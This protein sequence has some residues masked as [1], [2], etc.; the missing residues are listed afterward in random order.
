[1]CGGFTPFVSGMRLTTLR[2]MS[3]SIRTSSATM[4]CW[5]IISCAIAGCTNRPA[6]SQSLGHVDTQTC[7][8]STV[9]LV[10]SARAD[11]SGVAEHQNTRQRTDGIRSIGTI[12]DNRD[13]GGASIEVA[14]VSVTKD[15]VA[16]SRT[17]YMAT[18]WKVSWTARITV[19]AVPNDSIRNTSGYYSASRPF[20]GPTIAHS[21]KNISTESTA[22]ISTNP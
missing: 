3:N 17:A 2:R 7:H 6:E 12:L 13:G 10:T 21:T 5:I 4:A 18:T 1:M 22:R 15:I 11:G 20:I 9:S 19:E 14:Y 16:L 8:A